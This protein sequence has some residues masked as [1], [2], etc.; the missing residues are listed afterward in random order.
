MRRGLGTSGTTL[1][2]QHLNHSSARGEEEDQEIENLFEKIIEGNFL[3]LA[4]EIDFQEIQEAQSSKEVGPK[5]G[6]TKTH[7]N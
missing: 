6:H 1:N 2:I 3:N 7:Q 5:E 4:Q